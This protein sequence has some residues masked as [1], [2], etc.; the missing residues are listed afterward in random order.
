MLQ[1]PK[2]LHKSA[3]ILRK[4]NKVNYTLPFLRPN[5]ILL[6]ICQTNLTTIENLQLLSSWLI[7]IMI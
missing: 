3:D 2:K 6:R 4:P 7:N 1:S 5:P